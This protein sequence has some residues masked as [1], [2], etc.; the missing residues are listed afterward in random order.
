ML[1]IIIEVSLCV[2]VLVRERGGGR[3]GVSEKCFGN[4]KQI[5]VSDIAD[6]GNRLL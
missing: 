4:W 1:T 3:E 2:C 6:G 5:C